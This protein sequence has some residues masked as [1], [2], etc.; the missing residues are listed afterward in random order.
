MLHFLLSMACNG[1]LPVGVIREAASTF[2]VSVRTIGRIWRIAKD[3]MAS[4]QPFK[5]TTNYR[6]Y[7]RKRIQVNQED[8]AALS[9]GD[10]S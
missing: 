2:N 7:G 3:Q 6:N 4:N 8:V 10:R 1:I 5:I 9:M